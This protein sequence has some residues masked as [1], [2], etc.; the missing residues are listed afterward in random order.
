MEV[1]LSSRWKEGEGFRLNNVYRK[2]AL[3]FVDTRT[4][5]VISYHVMDVTDWDSNDG[6]KTQIK[7]YFHRKLQRGDGNLSAFHYI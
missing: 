3:L 2:F 5:N 1:S 7:T 6:E 4:L